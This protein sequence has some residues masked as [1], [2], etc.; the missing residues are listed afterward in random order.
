MVVISEAE[1]SVGQEG[2]VCIFVAGVLSLAGRRRGHRVALDAQCLCSDCLCSVKNIAARL[3]PSSSVP[4]SWGALSPGKAAQSFPV[5]AWLPP[6][7]ITPGT[8]GFRVTA[9]WP[10]TG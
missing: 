1:Q 6:E 3:R 5:S 4:S 10:L 7:T 8:A 9:E 2:C